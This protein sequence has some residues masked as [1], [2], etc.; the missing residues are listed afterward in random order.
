MPPPWQRTRQVAISARPASIDEVLDLVQSLWTEPADFSAED[1]IRFETAVIE[2]AGNIVTHASATSVSQ[3]IT[4]ELTLTAAP[5][6]AAAC[7]RDNGGAAD[8]DLAS[9][10]MPDPT[11]E[12]GRGLPLIRALTDVLTY[13]R[14]GPTNIWTIIC[15]RTDP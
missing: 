11:E 13:Q 8:L 4:I 12:S 10:T 9:A 6:Y 14:V 5:G 7:F 3:D 2:V 1:Q 15:R